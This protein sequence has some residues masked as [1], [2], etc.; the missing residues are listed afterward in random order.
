MSRIQ[1]VKDALASTVAKLSDEIKAIQAQGKTPAGYSLGFANGLIFANHHINL[2]DGEPKFFNAT[3]SVGTLPK[4]QPLKSAEEAAAEQEYEYLVDKVL[5]A[6][7]ELLVA[8]EATEEVDPTPIMDELK[9]AFTNLDSFIEEQVNME[10]AGQGEAQA[11][12]DAGSSD[13]AGASPAPAPI[14]FTNP[15]SSLAVPS[16]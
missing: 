7:R 3:T 11:A 1:R 6:S 16:P 10:K 15:E 14:D 8:H 13:Q 9:T 2:R 12:P 4:P 5:T